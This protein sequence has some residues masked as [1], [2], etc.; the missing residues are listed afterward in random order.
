MPRGNRETLAE[1]GTLFIG[2]MGENIPPL[3]LRTGKTS[4]LTPLRLEHPLFGFPN[5]EVS[6]LKES[7]ETFMNNKRWEDGG[8]WG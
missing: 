7:V 2:K 6:I 5:P 3:N 1:E 8:G 4:L